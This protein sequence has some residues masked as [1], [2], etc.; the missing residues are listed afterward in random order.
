MLAFMHVAMKNISDRY[1]VSDSLE[2]SI[3]FVLS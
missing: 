1:L 2:H 3:P